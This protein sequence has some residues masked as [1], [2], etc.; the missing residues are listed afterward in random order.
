MK[1]IS[2][3]FFI[4]Y[5]NKCFSYE[6]LSTTSSSECKQYVSSIS[7]VNPFESNAKVQ[8][9]GEFCLYN[10][11]GVQISMT[12]SG[13]NIIYSCDDPTIDPLSQIISCTINFGLDKNQS[14]TFNFN[15][16]NTVFIKTPIPIPD[17]S[18]SDSSSSG[19]SSTLSISPVRVLGSNTYLYT[20]QSCPGKCKDHGVCSIG[21]TCLCNE[22][23]A[24]FDCSHKITNDALSLPVGI[25]YSTFAMVTRNDIFNIKLQSVLTSSSSSSSSSTYQQQDIIDSNIIDKNETSNG[26]SFST[27]VNENSWLN[28]IK[29]MANYSKNSNSTLNKFIN[30]H[31]A[32]LPISS[33]SSQ[34]LIEPTINTQYLLNNGNGN[35]TTFEMILQIENSNN[36]MYSVSWEISDTNNSILFNNKKTNSLILFSLSDI[37]CFN[38]SIVPNHAHLRLLSNDEILKLLN[39]SST[40]TTSTE[41][42]YSVDSVYLSIVIPQQQQQLNNSTGTY[43][44][45]FAINAYN[46]STLKFPEWAIALIIVGAVASFAFVLFILVLIIRKKRQLKNLS[47]NNS[48]ENN[49]HHHHHHNNKNN[50]ESKPLLH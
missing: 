44:V 21:S 8:I 50:D 15:Q 12:L 32:Y 13:S 39:H 16:F 19:S 47:V 34:I 28:T 24:S 11:T 30:Y 36:D 37:Y 7:E 9:V 1:I 46:Y 5:L 43:Q 22:G 25:D 20:N 23:Y 29:Y 18:D 3:L 26:L 17:D 40:D 42:T 2:F 48:E 10:T 14:T 45:Q 6:Y 41:S 33:V 31:G 38:Q 4:I 27:I 35:G 49:N